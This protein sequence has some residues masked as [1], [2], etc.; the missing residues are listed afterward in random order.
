[1]VVLPPPL[2]PTIAN[3]SPAVIS[4]SMSTSAEARRSGYANETDSN[5]IVASC[6]LGGMV[7]PDA[8]SKGRSISISSLSA[9]AAPSAEAWNPAA[10]LR[11][12]R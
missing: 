5:L 8:T 9:T 4:S 12:G 11:S 2:V 1:M 7:E 3:V 6:R 10:R